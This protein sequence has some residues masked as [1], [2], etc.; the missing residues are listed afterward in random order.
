MLSDRDLPRASV[1]VER[2]VPQT[3][4][5]ELWGK[6]QRANTMQVA[7]PLARQPEEDIETEQNIFFNKT[8][9]GGPRGKADDEDEN[10]DQR[11]ENHQT[12]ISALHMSALDLVT[13]NI[14][15][16]QLDTRQR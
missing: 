12:N 10:E 6:M 2:P 11:R 8:L 5:D 7:S 4:E 14:N 9:L 15:K 13:G 1:K 16:E 3:G